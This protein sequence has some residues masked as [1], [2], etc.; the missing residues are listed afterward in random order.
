M[1]APSIEL[2]DD[3]RETLRELGLAVYR[4]K[5]ILEARP[6]ITQLEQ[7][8]IE[9]QLTGPI[10][11]GLMDLWRVSFGG[12]LDYDL[13]LDMDGHQYPASMR[14][15]FWPGSP[16]YHDLFGWMEHELEL[17]Q[18]AAEERDE[19]EPT[20]L[21]VLPFGGFEYL[22]RVY[23]FLEPE[24][25]GEVWLWAQG[26]P[27]AWKM[28]L[29][30]DSVV[31]VADDVA[32]LFDLIGLDA[33]PFGD[34]FDDYA[35][36]HDMKAAV[37]ELEPTHPALAAK[38]RS[39]IRASVF[40][41]RAVL[42]A[43][44]FEGLA[45]QVRAARLALQHAASNDDVATLD[46]ILAQGYPTD[47]VVSGRSTLLALAAAHGA[48]HVLDRLLD[49]GS[50]LGESPVVYCRGLDASMIRRLMARDVGFDIAAIVNLAE[51]GELAAAKAVFDEG[52]RQGD[53]HDP[54]AHVLQQV[55]Y[56]L[57]SAQSVESGKLTSDT[58]ADGYRRQA[59]LLG[60]LLRRISG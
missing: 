11:E 18:E 49:S 56:R 30:R 1:A 22:E 26:L 58:T 7:R 29:T 57:D 35:N 16:H 12:A 46:R 14:E 34:D 41:W 23:V 5:I 43:A 60:E 4:G 2:D 9:E 25:R 36:G 51:Q 42:E 8:Q 10:P 52:R 48:S 27:P 32:G 55:R 31:R 6:P 50:P 59:H 33:D 37:E 39:L 44:T 38:L 13:T 40:N 3:E 24:A 20:E 17:C 15:L 28:S 53:W 45:D 21:N 19:P 54:R 47:L